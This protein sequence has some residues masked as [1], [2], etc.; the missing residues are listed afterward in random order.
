M[1]PRNCAELC[2]VYL[3]F[4]CSLCGVCWSFISQ[5]LTDNW[6]TAHQ[7]PTPVPTTYWQ[8]TDN[9]Q[10]LSDNLLTTYLPTTCWQLTDSLSTALTIYWQPNCT[11]NLLTT[12]WQLTDNLSTTLTFTDDL[13]YQQPTDNWLTTDQQLTNNLLTTYQQLTDNW[14]TIYQ[15]PTDNLPTTD[16]QLTDN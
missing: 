7:Q 3:I 4:H 2:C 8:L 10:Q 13:L 9:L 1:V 14:P 11:N 6:L 5:W 12:D 15:Q 16:W